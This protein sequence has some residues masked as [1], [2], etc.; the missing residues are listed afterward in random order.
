[1]N[2]RGNIGHQFRH[3]NAQDDAEAAG[4]VLYAMM[5]DTKSTAPMEL[6]QA[7]KI[8]LGNLSE[9]GYTGRRKE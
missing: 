6:V 5:R 2:L 9:K 8:T 4:R 3:H 7:I 1:M